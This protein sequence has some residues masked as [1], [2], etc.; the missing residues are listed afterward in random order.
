MAYVPPSK[1]NMIVTE[2]TFTIGS[3]TCLKCGKSSGDLD[4]HQHCTRC[5]DYCLECGKKYAEFGVGTRLRCI[6]CRYLGDICQIKPMI[7]LPKI[8]K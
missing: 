1:R 8:H 5:K 7:N 2:Q 6:D 4:K 3:L